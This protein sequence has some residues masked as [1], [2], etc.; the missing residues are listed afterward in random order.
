MK[1]NQNIQPVPEDELQD[2]YAM[3][4]LV[5]LDLSPFKDMLAARKSQEEDLKRYGIERVMDG[6]IS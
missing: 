3:P 6:D 4:E 5:P 2:E 1:E